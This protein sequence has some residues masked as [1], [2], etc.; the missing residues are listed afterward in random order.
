MQKAIEMV[1][2][3]GKVVDDAKATTEN[4]EPMNEE[5]PS[6]LSVELKEVEYTATLQ[7]KYQHS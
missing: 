4:F 6:N 7:K 2:E 5:E 1:K 3:Y